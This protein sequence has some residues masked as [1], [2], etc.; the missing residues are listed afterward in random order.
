MLYTACIIC[1]NE[2]ACLSSKEAYAKPKR[3]KEEE[4][5][6]EELYI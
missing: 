5:E 6:E 2:E 4:K 3:R 1:A